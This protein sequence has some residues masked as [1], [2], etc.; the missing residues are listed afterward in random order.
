MVDCGY[1]RLLFVV[2]WGLAAVVVVVVVGG[3]GG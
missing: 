3:G 1:L 2:G